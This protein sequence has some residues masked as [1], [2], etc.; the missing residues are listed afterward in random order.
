MVPFESL[1]N[2]RFPIRIPLHS[3]C[4]RLEVPPIRLSTVGKW[5]FPAAGAN[6][7]NDLPFHITSA[8]SLAVFIQRLRTFLF[9]RS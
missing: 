5:E 3:A 2:L 4:H 6:M 1:V 9:S 8:P 7:W